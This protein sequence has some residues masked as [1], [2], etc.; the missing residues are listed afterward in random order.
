MGTL[1]LKEKERVVV[2]DCSV[3]TAS[4]FYKFGYDRFDPSLDGDYYLGDFVTIVDEETNRMFDLQVTEI[5]KTIS[6]K[7][8][9]HFDIKFGMNWYDYQCKLENRRK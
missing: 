7:G 9:E 2:F 4:K 6:E 5:E 3:N 1:S 8:E